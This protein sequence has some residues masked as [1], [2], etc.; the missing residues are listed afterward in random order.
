MSCDIEIKIFGTVA[1]PEAIWDLADSAAAEG[2]INWRETID[3]DAFLDLLVQAATEGRA[4]TLTRPETTD[5][6]EGVTAACKSAGLSYVVSYGDSGAEGFAEGF[7][8]QPGMDQEFHFLLDGKDPTLKVKDVRKAAQSGIEAVNAL[9]DDVVR[10]T[11]VGKIEIEP[12][13]TEAYRAF[14][15][16]DDAP[17]PY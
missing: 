3:R 17:I 6:F 2:R 9:I 5:F 13:F 16:G 1:N 15:D 10:H 14:A 4:L 7:S 11:R 12:G 8:W